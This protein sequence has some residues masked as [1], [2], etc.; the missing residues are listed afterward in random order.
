MAKRLSA[1]ER[2]A[3]IIK[4]AKRLFA[5]TGFHGVS[6]DEI[7]KEVGVSPAILYRH[8]ESK[9]ELYEA[10]LYEFSATRE[11]YVEAVVADD[12]SFEQVL[13][14]M[15]TVF[16]SSIMNH[17]D[18]LKME[19][20]SQLEG[21]EASQE[22]FLNRWKSFTDYIEYNLTELQSQK[23]IKTIN[24]EA[25]ALIYQGII[26]EVLLQKCMQ[27][28]DRFQDTPITTLVDEVINLFM[29]IIEPAE[30]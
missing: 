21:S 29:K 24:A 20:H 4:V 16:V 15:T 30:I 13:R 3:S 18:M 19:M 22:F 14:G 8:F 12:T 10:V 7:V 17:P 23:K 1:E 26:R 11:S 5:K 9:D 27:Q 2:R 6:I 28:T 25:A